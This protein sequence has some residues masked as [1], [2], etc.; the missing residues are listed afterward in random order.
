MK[1]TRTENP[2]PPIHIHITTSDELDK[3]LR[4]CEKLSYKIPCKLNKS[5]NIFLSDIHY[6]I[7]SVCG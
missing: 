5:E 1:V 7:L 6:A 2:F 3:I 4:I